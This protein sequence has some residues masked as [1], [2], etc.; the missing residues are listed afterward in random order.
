MKVLKLIIASV[1]ATGMFTSCGGSKQTVTQ[2]SPIMQEI[3]IENNECE[4]LQIQKPDIRA[5]GEGISKR[6]S[7]A[8]SLAEAQARAQFQR[9][10]E[11]II[12]TS[13]GEEGVRHG[14]INGSDEGEISNDN[15][16]AIAQ[17]V[18]KN[19]VIIKK[20][21]FLR[22]DGSYHV[23]VCLEYRG[24]RKALA[25][26]ITQKAKQQVS[27]DERLRNQYDFEKFRQRVEEEL[28]K[29]KAQ[30]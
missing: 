10:L 4:E 21:K 15:V 23:Y 14:G 13:Q 6:D 30:N 3:A 18:V 19:L 27:D 17:G 11:S 25:E 24:D 8:T 16:L 26:D 28:A 1:L 22:A 9:T 5:V 20:S 12:K 2:G 29:M 7:R